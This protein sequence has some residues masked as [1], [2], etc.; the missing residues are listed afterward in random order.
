MADALPVPLLQLAVGLQEG[1]EAVVE[2]L[3]GEG[4]QP[5]AEGLDALVEFS[6]LEEEAEA[7]LR[8]F[9]EYG[10][11]FEFVE[12]AI[13]V[14]EFEGGS[15]EVVFQQQRGLQVGVD[16]YLRHQHLVQRALDYLA[17]A[18]QL[19]LVVVLEED[20]LQLQLTG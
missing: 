7:A 8:Q 10:P 9:Y 11:V 4:D 19:L 12:E 2:L 20:L 16:D 15:E 14:A 1:P 6:D 13:D 17:L 3:L 5:L 18:D